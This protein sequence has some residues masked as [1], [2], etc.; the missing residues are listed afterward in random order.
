MCGICGLW[1]PDRAP[2]GEALL[3]RMNGRIVHRG[4][5]D[6]GYHLAP[7]V[8]LAM[9]RLAII[10]LSGGHQPMS[11]ADGALT[12]VFNGEIM[13]YLELRSQLEALG[14]TFRTQSDTEVCLG[15]YRQWG[16]DAWR[17]LAG[18]YAVAL[19]DQPARRLTLV[20]DPL[21]IKPLYYAELD[22]GLC[23]GSELKC[24]FEVPGAAGRPDPAALDEYLAFGYVHAPYTFYTRARKLLP[25]Q[26]LVAEEGRA[27]R[28]ETY[29]QLRF[30]GEARPEERWIS[31]LQ[32]RFEDTVRR[33]LISDV[34]LG[35]FLSGGVDSSAVVA[36]MR[37]VHPGRVRTFSIGFREQEFNELPYARRVAEHLHTEHLEETVDAGSAESILPLLAE[38]YDEPFADSSAVPTWYV[39]RVTR[40]HVTV[41]LSGD[42]G[43][44]LFA[45]YPRYINE[46]WME[47]WRRVPAPLR[48]LARGMAA[49]VPTGLG[50]GA[51]EW[52]QRAL[53]RFEDAE[54]PDTFTRW[55]AKNQWTAP[56]IRDSIYTRAYARTLG[57]DRELARYV[58]RHALGPVSRDPVENLLYLDTVYRLPDDMLTKVD[59]ASMAHS[60]EVRVPFLDHTLVEF[61]ASMPVDM[62]LRGTTRKYALKRMIRPWLP[63]G[64]LDR[65]KR[66]FAVPLSSWFRS[67]MGALT[68][69]WMRRSGLYEDGQLEERG[70]EAVV[71]EHESGRADR[72]SLLYS[73]MMLAAWREGPDRIRREREAEAPSTA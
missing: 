41:A 46:R 48:R 13:N 57:L 25:G 10:D 26:L 65:P 61:I 42:G 32:E 40:A 33:H 59:R 47:K 21:G 28:T 38:H 11:T 3:R 31:E 73:L 51:A 23:F 36:A 17:R 70:I 29:W 12:V 43:D 39:S 2:V 7:G 15:A 58:A 60:L 44:E 24:L 35:A 62:K 27:L 6:E 20:R 56:G 5:D 71:K 4:P 34:P 37:R 68:L 55:F 69:E 72:S 66:G 19:W 53:K 45:G 63:E 22:R 67:G 64:I 14:Q 30:G 9:R 54:L 16:D 18:M 49:A 8:G 52:R 1:Y 50:A